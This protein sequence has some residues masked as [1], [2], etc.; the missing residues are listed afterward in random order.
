M[1]PD[2]A[3]LAPAPDRATAPARAGLARLLVLT[4]RHASARP[5][6]DGVRAAVECGARAV[7]LREKDLPAADR[8][9]PA[10]EVRAVLGDGLLVLAGTVLP[11]EAL[12][13]SAAA[14]VP[15]VRPHL[16]GRSGHDAGEVARAA[17][18]SCDWA[19]VSPI[20]TT[21]AKPGYAPAL[22][23]PGLAALLPGAPPAYALGGV[24]N[25]ASA[26]CRQA[27]ACGVAAVGAVLRA[28]RPEQLVAG[29]L[30]ALGESG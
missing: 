6:A 13:L 5:L 21:A 24:T 10:D 28:D 1:A 29:L 4:D 2:P 15:A 8:L 22:G 26:P 25:P 11:G 19:S 23:V 18:Q 17:Q 9:R 30:H 12:H 7:V 3:D 14:A 20:W 27:D 16:L